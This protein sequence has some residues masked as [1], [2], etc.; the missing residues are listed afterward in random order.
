MIT[1]F[2]NKL[3]HK[4][5][6]QKSYL[7]LLDQYNNGEYP[8]EI[9]GI[10]GLYQASLIKQI[11]NFAKGS[12]FIVLPTDNDVNSFLK[13]LRSIHDDVTEFP[14]WDTIPYKGIPASSEICGRRIEALT[15]IVFGKKEMIVMPLRALINW[16]MP[17]KD[18]EESIIHINKNKTF[19]PMEISR[20]LVSMGY[21]KVPRATVG[22]EFA[23]RGEVLD[24]VCP[25]KE[26]GERVVFDFDNVEKIRSFDPANQETLEDLDEMLIYPFRE[27][28]WTDEK[29][30]KLEEELTSI[31][32]INKGFKPLIEKLRTHYSCENEELLYPVAFKKQGCILDYFT[33]NDHLLFINYERI[34]TN[35]QTLEKEY[36]ELFKEALRA[37]TPACR[38][39][40]FLHSFEELVKDIKKKIIFPVIH[41]PE[42]D[43]NRISFQ[44]SGPRSFFREHTVFKRGAQ[45]PC[46]LRI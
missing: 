4:L 8:L 7:S 9:I 10:D 37:Q 12:F 25:G 39:S 19:D 46:R 15:K 21:S 38:P 2:L 30:N 34:T 29:I 28:I 41:D 43:I 20:Q 42:K 6:T 31:S 11:F 44:Y 14:W 27:I 26:Y 22:G 35:L 36:N 32:M 16:V 33:E 23:L 13:D 5:K 17:K 45:Q 1:L 24:I 40:I 3:K 18:L